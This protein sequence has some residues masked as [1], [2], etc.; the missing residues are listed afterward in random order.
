[1]RTA[2][3]TNVLS[4]IFSGEQGAGDLLK[5]LYRAKARGEVMIC[6]VVYAELLA[7]PR[8]VEAQL[9]DFLAT[10]GIRTDYSLGD[11]VWRTAGIRYAR[12]VARRRRSASG[13]GPRRILA[14]FLIGAHALLNADRLMTIDRDGFE[15]D[16]PELTLYL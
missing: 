12:H 8:L 2:V 16:F 3:D 10:S 6:G 5:G 4:A 9:L 1:M 11:K 15:K 7:H 13:T 14:D